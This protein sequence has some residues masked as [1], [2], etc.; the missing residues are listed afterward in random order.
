MTTLHADPVWLVRLVWLP[1]APCCNIFVGLHTLQ[2]IV[3]YIDAAFSDLRDILTEEI[4]S[5]FA[6]SKVCFWTSAA[7]DKDDLRH[8]K[9]GIPATFSKAGALEA[10]PIPSAMEYMENPYTVFM[11][12]PTAQ[13]DEAMGAEGLPD[14]VDAVGRC[15]LGMP[16]CGEFCVL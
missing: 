3:S 6:A 5:H 11:R 15:A 4:E 12:P 7:L 16:R 1:D 2:D 8:L 14:E 9:A 10:E 13:H